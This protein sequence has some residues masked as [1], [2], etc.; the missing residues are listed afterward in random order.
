MPASRYAIS[1][2]AYAML[3]CRVDWAIR[4]DMPPLVDVSNDASVAE[5]DSLAIYM[6]YLV[7]IGPIVEKHQ[8]IRR[9][10][11]VWLRAKFHDKNF[12]YGGFYST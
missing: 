3:P 12:A 1:I 2:E 6:D 11:M 7:S 5:N 4:R 8:G 9:M 10:V